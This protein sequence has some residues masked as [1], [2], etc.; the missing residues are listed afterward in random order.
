MS[1][2]VKR[3]RDAQRLSEP[4]QDTDGKWHFH[5]TGDHSTALVAFKNDEVDVSTLADFIHNTEGDKSFR[6]VIEKQFSW[7]P[8]VQP[9]ENGCQT[10]QSTL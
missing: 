5:P 3:K 6:Q 9:Q 10:V 1:L 7:R 2:L 8:N 4:L